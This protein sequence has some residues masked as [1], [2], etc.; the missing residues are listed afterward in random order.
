M[1]IAIPPRMRP[2]LFL[3]APLLALSAWLLPGCECHQG[4]NG[5]V[6]CNGLFPNE[7]ITPRAC[8][9]ETRSCDGPET[10]ENGC[11][12][13]LMS[14]PMNCGG[15]DVVCPGDVGVRCNEGVC[16]IVCPY[17]TSLCGTSCVNLSEDPKSCGAC[18]VV[19]DGE[20]ADGLCT[21]H[22]VWTTPGAY[23][24]ACSDT[25]VFWAGYD[26]I[27]TAAPASSTFSQ[28][29]ARGSVV[30]LA[31]DLVV[32]TDQDGVFSVPAAGG[33]VLSLSHDGPGFWLVND[34]SFAYFEDHGG[35]R[36]A[37]VAGGPLETILDDAALGG[38]AVIGLAVSG[39]VLYL[40]VR[41]VGADKEARILRMELSSMSAPT[42]YGP[43]LGDLFPD[44]E[45][46]PSGAVITVR[47][48]GAGA[49]IIR[50]DAEDSPPV[51]LASVGELVHLA[52]VQDGSLFYID[53]NNLYELPLGADGA[54]PIF[55]AHDPFQLGDACVL[56]D[57]IYFTSPGNGEIRRI[58]RSP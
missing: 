20:C 11:E 6:G 44:V 13:F 32:S 1:S 39:D 3:A 53:A 35:V 30:S 33:D 23:S 42:D 58:T 14:D 54:T 19:C 40:A 8:T 41:P 4:P 43:S 18:G 2:S 48:A 26:A 16:D 27:Y 12:T 31:G 25:A 37:P 10:D 21:G 46:A 7:T 45:I 47:L 55:R 5:A 22:A 29:A 24:I 51:V 49:E 56:G 17:Q 52:G 38:D 9:A 34:G 15:C 57:Q 50:L 28:I 36:R